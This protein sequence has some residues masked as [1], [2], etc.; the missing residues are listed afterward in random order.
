M[1]CASATSPSTVLGPSKPRYSHTITLSAPATDEWTLCPGTVKGEST[2][3][4]LL[5][6]CQM[7][8]TVSTANGARISSIIPTE[9]SLTALEPR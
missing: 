6:A 7:P 8:R 9:Y 4:P 2:L 1:R 5:T 3:I